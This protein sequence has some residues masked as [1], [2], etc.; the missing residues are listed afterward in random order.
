MN[1]DQNF[2]QSI[3]LL[4]LATGLLLLIPLV[5][6]QF[7]TEVS[8]TLGDFLI[9][10]GLIFGTGLAY[11]LVT[12]SSGKLPYRMAAGLALAGGFMLIWVNGAVGIIGNESLSANL[13]YFGVIGT[14]IMGAIIARLQSG[15]MAYAM[16]ATALVQAI[17][18]VIA[19]MYWPPETNSWG[20][21]GVSGVFIFNAGFVMLFVASGLLFRYV[22]R[23]EGK[24]E[25]NLK[26]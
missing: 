11:K 13:L 10:G 15:P 7:T 12:R 23:Q 1:T 5:A 25:T 17:I 14:G 19:L 4:A 3:G 16:F 8:W 22:A 26:S 6:M 2:Y 20:A 9:M 18:P 24:S 21:A